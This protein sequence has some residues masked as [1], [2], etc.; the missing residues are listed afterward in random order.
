[1][2]LNGKYRV[3]KVGGSY[4]VVRLGE[5]QDVNLSKL[6]TLNETGAFIFNRIT[7]GMEADGIAAAITEEYD[8]GPEAALEAV[9]TYIDKLGELGIVER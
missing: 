2:K 1:M 8:I 9:N 3:R 4:I 6:I 5:G 7:E